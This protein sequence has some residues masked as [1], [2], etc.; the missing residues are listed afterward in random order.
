MIAFAGVLALC[1][2]WTAQASVSVVVAP[3]GYYQPYTD[4]FGP[5]HSLT[6]VDVN[7]YS[8]ASSGIHGA[9]ES[10]VNE[11]GTWAQDQVYCADPGGF[12]YH[13]FCGCQLRRGWNGTLSG[14]TIM[15]GHE[16]Y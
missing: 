6:L 14:D 12:V 5:R 2:A 9:C 13:T 15:L 16:Y 11:D 4:V 7:N 3:Y 8:Q 1:V 10:A